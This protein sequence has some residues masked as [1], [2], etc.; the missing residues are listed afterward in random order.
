MGW[1]GWMDQLTSRERKI[2]PDSEFRIAYEEAI[3]YGGKVVLG[4]RPA[5]VTK[6][7]AWRKMTL[8]EIIKGLPSPFLLAKW[9]KEVE[10]M[11]LDTENRNTQEL[12]KRFP[13]W[14]EAFIHERDIFMAKGILNVAKNKKSS[15]VVAVV[16]RVHLE[17]IKKHLQH[18]ERLSDL[19]VDDLL[20]IPPPKNTAKIITTIG[21]FMAG[22]A[23]IWKCL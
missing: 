13:T 22:V 15:R 8:S 14:A 12:S 2:V 1:M 3:K 16:G 7:R 20:T 23:I 11:D 9:S 18:Q 10:K 5:E 6:K 4:D 21:V 17:G 19:S